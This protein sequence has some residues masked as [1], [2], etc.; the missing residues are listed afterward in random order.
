MENV[1]IAG[2]AEILNKDNVSLLAGEIKGTIENCVVI[3]NSYA[4]NKG[5]S[6]N[7]HR[8]VLGKMKAGTTDAKVTNV[9]LK[10]FTTNYALCTGDTNNNVD[11][12]LNDDRV[13]NLT[14][15]IHTGTAALRTALVDFTALVDGENNKLN[16]FTYNA[17]TY[18]L[19]LN[20]NA[21]YTVA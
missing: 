14:R 6:K 13:E 16:N 8:A 5:T 20:G 10:T 19:Y 7:V 17:D 18:T 4:Y 2:Y 9:I 12:S 15:I 11:A 3:D 1:F 21:I